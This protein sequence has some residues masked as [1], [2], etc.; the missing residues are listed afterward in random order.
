MTAIGSRP[1]SVVDDGRYT[2]T[3]AL[4]PR[5]ARETPPRGGTAGVRR[6]FRGRCLL[7]VRFRLCGLEPRQSFGGLALAD[8]PDVVLCVHTRT[9]PGLIRRCR[10]SRRYLPG[11]GFRSRAR[12]EGVAIAHAPPSLHDGL[13]SFPKCQGTRPYT[14]GGHGIT[15]ACETACGESREVNPAPRSASRLGRHGVARTVPERW[16]ETTRPLR[17]GQST[18]GTPGVGREPRACRL[19]ARRRKGSRSGRICWAG[20]R[21]SRAVTRIHQGDKTDA[22]N[23]AD[24]N[25]PGAGEDAQ[26][27]AFGATPYVP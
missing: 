20:M 15:L 21:D 26:P 7:R 27:S 14:G 9:P 3:T 8:V 16:R 22:Q 13:Q 18:R 5:R 2:A 25:V 17:S 19:R 1:G 24:S 12:S 11:E 4:R 23:P 10:T 6:L